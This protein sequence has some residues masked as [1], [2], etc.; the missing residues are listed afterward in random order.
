MAG[1]GY[2]GML[3]GPAVIGW[4]THLVALNHTF[5]LLTLLC[6]TTAVG[7]RVL[8]AE[9]DRTRPREPAASSH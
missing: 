7:A 4:L 9:P 6:V 5:L 1:L 8:R 2:V 3:A